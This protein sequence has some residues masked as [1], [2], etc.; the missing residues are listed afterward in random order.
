MAWVPAWILL[1]F[2]IKKQNRAC[3]AKKAF[4]ITFFTEKVIRQILRATLCTFASLP[5]D[6]LVK[7]G[8]YRKLSLTVD[9]ENVGTTAN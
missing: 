5:Q 1:S 3:Y 6:F 4:S 9:S 2:K 8:N 7:C